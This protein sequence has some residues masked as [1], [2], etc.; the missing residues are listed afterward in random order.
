VT[1]VFRVSG[2]LELATYHLHRE[3]QIK[4]M[5]SIIPLVILTYLVRRDFMVN[6]SRK[7]F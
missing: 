5:V 7:M 1:G 3:R 4:L 2:E 6:A